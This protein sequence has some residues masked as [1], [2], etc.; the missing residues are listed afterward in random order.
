L[1]PPLALLDR[2]LGHPLGVL[3]TTRRGSEFPLTALGF[4]Y[5]LLFYRKPAGKAKEGA[6]MPRTR[7]VAA[8]RSRTPR[9][10]VGGSRATGEDDLLLQ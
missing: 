10:R 6:A 7:F 2:H 4:A 3:E 5:V 1:L 8:C 9:F